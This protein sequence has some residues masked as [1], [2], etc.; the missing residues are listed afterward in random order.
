M[1]KLVACLSLGVLM[2]LPGLASAQSRAVS[3]YDADTPGPPQARVSFAQQRIFER[4]HWEARQRSDRL[5]T[6]KWHEHSV[7]RPRV[8]FPAMTAAREWVVWPDL[9]GA[10][11]HHG[12]LPY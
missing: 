6:R 3:Y 8:R 1:R 4:A 10:Y 12:F 2:A 7:L 11:W 9:Y 5:E